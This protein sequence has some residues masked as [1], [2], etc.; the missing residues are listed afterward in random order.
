MIRKALIALVLLA[1][2][3]TAHTQP[4]F[5]P[6]VQVLEACR[7]GPAGS[8]PTGMAICARE[9]THLADRRLATLIGEATAPSLGLRGV[10]LSASQMHWQRYRDLHCGLFDRREGSSG[11]QTPA[12]IEL[13]RLSRTLHRE[14]ELRELIYLMGPR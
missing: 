10:D 4:S 9:A 8:T 13:C 6:S 2:H 3:R 7:E 1:G 5:A 14:S 12:D 11:T